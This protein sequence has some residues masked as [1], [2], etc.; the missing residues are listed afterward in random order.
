MLKGH[1]FPF[2]IQTYQDQSLFFVTLVLNA[3]CL[4][5]LLWFLMLHA[6]CRGYVAPEYATLGQLSEKVDVFSFGVLLFEIISGRRNIDSNQP[7]EKMYLL[8]QVS[9]EE[10]K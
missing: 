7:V 10:R 8:E 6:F 4:F 5:L 2:S 9:L 1:Q 3:I